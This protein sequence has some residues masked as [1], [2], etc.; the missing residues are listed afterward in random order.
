MNATTTRL[1]AALPLVLAATLG[2]GGCA[3]VP[4]AYPRL[5]QA[6]ALHGAA[7]SDA[8]IARF[9]AAELKTADEALDRARLARETLDDP[10]VVDHL[11]YVAK[12]RLAIAREAAGLRAAQAT[13]ESSA[14]RR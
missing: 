2:L 10:A 7:R 8:V 5:D 6:Q 11:A 1:S 3:F 12:Q 14:Q 4:K 13:I 9:A